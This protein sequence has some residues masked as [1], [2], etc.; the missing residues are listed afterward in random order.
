MRYYHIQE[1]SFVRLSVIEEL[2]GVLLSPDRLNDQTGC[3]KAMIIAGLRLFRFRFVLHLMHEI[4]MHTALP[5]TFVRLK[6]SYGRSQGACMAGMP[7]RGE[8]RVLRDVVYRFGF[9]WSQSIENVLNR[10][11]TLLD[12]LC[13]VLSEIARDFN[14]KVIL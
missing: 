8:C 10:S 4:G 12:G 3:A 13:T 7:L 14:G 2:L 11:I 5:S 9:G 6:S 1:S